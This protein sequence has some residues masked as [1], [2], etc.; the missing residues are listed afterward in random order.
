MDVVVIGA[1]MT[2]LATAYE[3]K[4]AR[5]ETSITVLEAADR[6]GGKIATVA[7]DRITLETGA[8]SFLARDRVAVDLCEE[9]QL[10][11]RLV[12]PEVFGAAVFADGRLQRLPNGFVY[13]IPSSLSA[14]ARAQVLS[15][16]GR[17]RASADLFLPG[18][19]TDDQS[20]GSFVRLRFG[21]ELLEKVVDP[22]LAGTR[23]GDVDHMSLAASMPQIFQVA[24][25]SRSMIRG[26][27]RAAGTGS[28]DGG[29]PPFLTIADG[30]SRLPESLAATLDDV[31]LSTGVES[32][33]RGRRYS[34]ITEHETMDAHCVVVTTPAFVSAK[35]VGSL[36]DR[37][38]AALATIDHAS[39]ASVALVYDDLTFSPPTGTSGLLVGSTEQKAIAGCTWYS[40]KWRHA[41]PPEA[42]VLRCFVGRAGK[43]DLL[44]KDDAGIVAAVVDDL[45]RLLGISSTPRDVRVTRWTDG[46]PQ[47]AVGHL[48]TISYAEKALA[49]DAPG[50]YVSGADF[51]GSGIPD[52][53]RQGERAARMT[54][55]ALRSTMQAGSR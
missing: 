43:H 42:S 6:V 40:T 53:I 12:S 45:D 25:S 22:L 36:S 26:L 24:R 20:V 32:I 47:Y 3:I 55:D 27:A 23:A 5:P 14:V 7:T 33:E 38:S 52:C 9:L 37:A 15:L 19:A 18:Q 29:R 1:G 46:L 51:R 28:I 13:G 16:R 39:V 35:L 44:Q 11:N 34:V 54:I 31:R 8:D 17:V 4:K 2:G 48:D 41:A 21:R 49:D 10:G 50:V 30:L